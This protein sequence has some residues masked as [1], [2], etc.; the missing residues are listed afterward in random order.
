MG[1]TAV[2]DKN[3]ELIF[4]SLWDVM[5]IVESSCNCH[6]GKLY[7]I[8]AQQ[9]I[10]IMIYLHLKVVFFFSIYVALFSLCLCCIKAEPSPFFPFFFLFL[11]VS[12]PPPFTL[13]TPFLLLLIFIFKKAIILFVFKS[14]P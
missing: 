1:K 8:T 13:Y 4:R 11:R 10:E 2:C 12:N 6:D 9:S 5:F 3:A 7:I 14:F